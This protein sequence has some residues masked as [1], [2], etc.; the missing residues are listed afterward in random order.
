MAYFSCSKKQSFANIGF[1]FDEALPLQ[2][3]SIKTVMKAYWII[4]ALAAGH[5]S[6]QQQPASKSEKVIQEIESDD[7]ASIIRNPVSADQPIDTVH[8][9]KI[10]FEQ[11]SYD[12]GEVTEGEVVI[13]D[14]KFTNTGKVPLLITDA[15]STCGCTVP[16]WPK[17]QIAPGESSVISVQFNTTNK[18]QQQQKPITITA[19]TYPS[20]TKV[21]LNG[22]VHPKKP[23]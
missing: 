10:T 5:F 12:F 2:E 15:R 11:T 20:E 7:I 18:L 6:C 4:I 19:N 8:V 13:H 14:F 23:S 1:L 3:F 16:D 22:Y 17:A 9:A 21:Y